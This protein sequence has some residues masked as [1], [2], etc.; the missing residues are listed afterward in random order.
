MTTGLESTG[1]CDN[2][3][4][5]VILMYGLCLT[6]KNR[7]SLVLFYWYKKV[8]LLNHNNFLQAFLRNC[9]D[10]NEERDKCEVTTTLS[11]AL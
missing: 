4:T 10:K 7:F 5:V 3:T 11:F 1:L 8:R 2:H 6:E 9:V